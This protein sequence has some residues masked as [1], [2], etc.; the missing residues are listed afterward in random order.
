MSHMPILI[1]VGG[2]LGAT[3]DHG[4]TPRL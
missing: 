4:R 3:I 2:F 1:H